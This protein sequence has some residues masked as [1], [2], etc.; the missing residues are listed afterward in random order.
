MAKANIGDGVAVAEKNESINMAASSATLNRSAKKNTGKTPDAARWLDILYQT[1][2]DCQRAG[3]SVQ[4]VNATA[5]GSVVV[6]R[7]VFWCETHEHFT[8]GESCAACT[9]TGNATA[10]TSPS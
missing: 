4:I 3:I 2:A 7:G 6:L 9:S 10:E 8:R 1:L 5:G